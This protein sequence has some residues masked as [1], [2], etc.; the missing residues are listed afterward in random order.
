MP[1]KFYC[2][3]SGYS[4]IAIGLGRVLGFE[5]MQNF[6]LPYLARNVREFWSRWHIS[7]STWFRDYVYIAL[8][9]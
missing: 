3:F 1:F 7:L 9:W 5:L 6:N 4:D 2:D 8:G